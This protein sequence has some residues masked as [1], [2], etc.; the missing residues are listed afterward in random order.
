VR[1]IKYADRQ[2]HTFVG[3]G[4]GIPVEETW[5]DETNYCLVVPN[6]WTDETST[7][8]ASGF[9]TSEEAWFLTHTEG[10]V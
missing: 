4:P 6:D 2:E 8:M 9:S 10:L 1:P 3:L 5:N 7:L